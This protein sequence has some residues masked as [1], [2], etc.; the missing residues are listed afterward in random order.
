MLFAFK[1]VWLFPNGIMYRELFGALVHEELIL[2]IS[3]HALIL[4]SGFAARTLYM[5]PLI[6][7]INKETDH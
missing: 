2:I 7:D 6:T 5:F 1:I 4:A 3:T